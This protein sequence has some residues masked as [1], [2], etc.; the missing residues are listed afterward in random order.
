MGDKSI[1][2]TAACVRIPVAGIRNPCT[3]NSIRTMIWSSSLDHLLKGAAWNAV[4]I[5]EIIVNKRNGQAK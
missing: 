5:A 2:V 4:H 1:E 3:L